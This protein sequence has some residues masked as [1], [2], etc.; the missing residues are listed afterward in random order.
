MT[1]LADRTID[2]LR[3]THARLARRVETLSDE[4]IARPS[5]AQEWT[6]AQV[7]S[8]LGSGAEIGLDTLRTAQAGRQRPTDANQAVWARWDAM[9][10][11]EQADAFLPASAEL[12]SAFEGLN[13]EQRAS[14]RVPLAFLPEP[15]D[16][17]LLTGLRLNEASLHTWDVEVAFDPSASLPQD[18]A[19]VQL[20]QQHGP[21][22]FMLRRLAKTEPIAPRTVLLIRTTAPQ[23]TLGLDLDNGAT[24]TDEPAQPDG[25]LRLPADALLRLFTGR[26]PAER[27]PAGV[28]VTGPLSL[29]KL[30]DI[31]PG[32]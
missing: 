8:H 24:L 21:L 18:V 31:F 11:R 6:V 10:A 4:D 28:H 14:L 17:A 5:G 26:L 27:T 16:V 32:F 29:A 19:A 3:S 15:A 20:D 1:T 30:R 25:E 23:R 7:L 12:V 13:A 22:G 2:A 9:S